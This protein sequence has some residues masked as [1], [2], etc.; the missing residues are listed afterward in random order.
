MGFAI[1]LAEWFRGGIHDFARAYI[2]EREDSYLSSSFVDKMWHQH[3]SGIRDWS[4]Q[5][6]NVLMF[7]L[8]QNRFG[9]TGG[10]R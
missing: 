2:T 3:Q 8:W 7:R 10:I 4:S 1:P 9:T 5:L 6:W